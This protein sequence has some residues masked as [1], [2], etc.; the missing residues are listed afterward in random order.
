MKELAKNTIHWIQDIP[1]NE[2]KESTALAIRE[3]LTFRENDVTLFKNLSTPTIIDLK[4]QNI[5]TRDIIIIVREIIRKTAKT[6]KYAE[7]MTLEQATTLASDLIDLCKDESIEDFILMFKMA[8]MGKCG[9]TKGRLDS[10][11]ITQVIVPA[12]LDHK[13]EL[14]EKQYQKEKY[15]KKQEDNE[16]MSPEA[17]KAF[18]EL[19]R[20]LSVPKKEE[21]EKPNTP[22]LNHHHIYLEN[23]KKRIPHYSLKLLMETE[24]KMIDQDVY[25]DAL[26]IV[27]NEIR[28]RK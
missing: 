28:K 7:N 12:Y 2:D 26:E 8:R 11:I 1:K 24:E 3:E 5:S 4:K 27:R 21:P 14:R 10:D 23:L 6:F 9:E 19:Y 25:K 17:I 20:R 13:A 18:D 15:A 16:G 22:V